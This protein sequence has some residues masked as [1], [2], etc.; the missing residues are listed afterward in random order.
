MPIP[1]SMLVPGFYIA[2]NLL[3]GDRAAQDAPLRAL[4]IT[5]KDANGTIT[6]DTEIVA[7]V[8]GPVQ[9]AGLVGP[10]TPG[11]L[12]AKAIFR[13]NPITKL[14]V[15]CAAEPAGSKASQ[16]ITFD[17]TTPVTVTQT[18]EVWVS[19]RKVEIAWLPG[20]TEIEVAAKLTAAVNAINDDCPVVASD[21]GTEVTTFT[22]KIK[23]KWGNDITLRGKMTGG[24]GG[25]MT[26]GGS[27]RLAGGT[28]EPS[29]TAILAL[30]AGTQYDFIVLACSGNADAADS[31]GTSNVS[32]LKTHITT[33]NSGLAALL[34]QGIVASTGTSLSALKAGVLVVNE[35][36]CQ[37]VYARDMESLPAELAGA[38]AGARLR[39]TAIDAG[40]NRESRTDLPYRAALYPPASISSSKLTPIELNDALTNGISPVGYTTSG[41]PYIIEPRTMYHV[42]GLGNPDQRVRWVSKVDVPY[43]IG[44]DLR[45]YMPSRF[46][47]VKLVKKI[48]PAADRKPRKVVDEATIKSVVVAR[49]S[50][51]WAQEKGN[52]DNDSLLAAEK[53]G[54]L[55]ID[56]NTTNGRVTMY[57][58]VKT[59][60][61]LTQWDT[62]VLGS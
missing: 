2:F 35:M 14:D 51:V 22:A 3:A 46:P 17:D 21:G 15:G 25:A 58:P 43:A 32:K 27:G 1:N 39:E 38:E 8:T 42:D 7:S 31:G 40:V 33:Y 47:D 20:E 13:E 11:H 59:L 54:E 60:V 57:L 19:G 16:T 5:T 26:V 37:M 49:L 29:V 12:C 18:I 45:V 56:I 24:T 36:T 62:T 9:V 55:F 28:L 6:A 23:G 53:S 48:D 10:G 41:V 52:I 4:L 30:A 61:P 50:G 44:R 34:Q